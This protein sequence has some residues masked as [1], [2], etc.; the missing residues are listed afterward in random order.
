[1]QL[2]VEKSGTGHRRGWLVWGVNV[3]PFCKMNILIKRILVWAQLMH[4]GDSHVCCISWNIVGLHSL[5]GKASLPH[6][7]AYKISCHK[8]SHLKSSFWNYFFY[9]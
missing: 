5:P 2:E 8:Q 4:I 3:R 7:Q 9:L 1:M 6:S